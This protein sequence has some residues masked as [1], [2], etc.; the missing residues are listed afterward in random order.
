MNNCACIWSSSRLMRLT[1]ADGAPPSCRAAA[2]KL[3]ARAVARKALIFSSVSIHLSPFEKDDPA[4]LLALGRDVPSSFLLL[5]KLSAH[6]PA[7]SAIWGRL[8]LLQSGRRRMAGPT[9]VSVGT[10][11]VRRG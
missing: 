6:D 11:V 7:F 4:K 9:G 1:I 3:P 10:H 5:R 8:A 2:E